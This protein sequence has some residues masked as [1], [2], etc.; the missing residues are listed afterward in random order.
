VV[1]GQLQHGVAEGLADGALGVM[2]SVERVELRMFSSA[3]WPRS[4]L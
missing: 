3:A 1:L 4:S 2:K